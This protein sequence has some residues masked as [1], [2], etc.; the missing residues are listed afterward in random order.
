VTVIRVPGSELASSRGGP[1]CMACP[2]GRDPAAE[3]ESGE[4][5]PGEGESGGRDEG[6][7]QIARRSLPA[8]PVTTVSPALDPELA[9]A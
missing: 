4:G 3:G 2:I 6:D 1:R 9:P 5:V 8:A 7:L